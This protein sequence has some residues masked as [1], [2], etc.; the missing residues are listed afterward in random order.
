MRRLVVWT[1]TFA[2]HFMVI[3]EFCDDCGRRQPLVW[4]SSDALWT[5]TTGKQSVLTDGGGVLCPECFD[6]KARAN[7]LMLRWVPVI[8]YRGHDR[9]ESHETYMKMLA[10]EQR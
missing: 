10:G 9:V 8:E 3:V 7:G 2:C 6:K 5:E 1:K 4:T